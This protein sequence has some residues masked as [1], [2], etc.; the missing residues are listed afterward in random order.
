MSTVWKTAGIVVLACFLGLFSAWSKYLKDANLLNDDWQW[1]FLWIFTLAFVLQQVHLAWPKPTNRAVVASRSE[2]IESFLQR[3]LEDYHRKVASL[4]RG[5]HVT[6]PEVRA[7]VML[8]TKPWRGLLGE[9]LEICYYSTDDDFHYREDETDLVW[10]KGQG[11]CGAAWAK[12]KPVPYDSA[13]KDLKIPAGK[14]TAGQKT[15]TS[16]LRSLLSV[17]IWNFEA[18]RIVGVLNLDSRQNKGDS[19][20]THPEV[21]TLSAAYATSLAPLCYPDGVEPR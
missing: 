7:N 3:L 21:A 19:F 1:R 18:K 20:L 15:A 9:N 6:K 8:V 10:K 16:H 12:Q 17:P 11:A 14:L 4:D 5:A 13:N 2:V